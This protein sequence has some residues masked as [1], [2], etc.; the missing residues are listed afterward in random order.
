LKSKS[1]RFETILRTTRDAAEWQAALSASRSVFGS[2]EFARI[3]ER[4]SGFESRLLMLQSDAGQIAYPLF[5]RP[6]GDLAKA[7]HVQA[8][9]DT[10][11]ADYTGPFLV[12]GEVDAGTRQHI[13]E[14][15]QEMG[16]VAEFIHLRVD[17][18]EPAFFSPGD[19]EHNRDVVHVDL[20]VE[21]DVLWRDHF[22]HAC[23]KN[24]NRSVRENVRIFEAASADHIREFHRIYT[25]TMDRNGA[26]ARYYFPYEF[27]LAFFE[28]MPKHARFVL[29]EHGGRIAAATLY[30]HDDA[31][32]YSYLGGANLEFQQV[33]PTNAIIYDTIL[34]GQKLGKKHLVLG[35]GYSKDDN[36]FRFKQ[37]FSPLTL[38][39][40]VVK[41]IH[42]PEAYG[43]LCDAWRLSHPG[44]EP[45][46]GYFP[47]YRSQ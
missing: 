7:A 41:R 39:F 22:Q 6:L 16:A 46:S 29:A 13:H 32:I 37:T 43:A 30:L 5:L 45:Q 18:H 17:G 28:S 1:G 33:R 47:A 4:Q 34:W 9:C 35:G 19:L 15:F 14:A 20:T 8:T 2:V 27:F 10:M 31:N 42:M 24:I 38:P 25:Q 36:I 12:R 44:V 26:L 40:S 3:Y 21:K 23:R 11:T